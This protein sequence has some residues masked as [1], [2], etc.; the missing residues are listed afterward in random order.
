MHIF[1]ISDPPHLLKTACNNVR[2][3]KTDGSK[4]LRFGE[5]HILWKHFCQVPHLYQTNKLQSRKLHCNHFCNQSYGK[6]KVRYAAQLLSDT[7]ANLM[8]AR[9]E[10][11]K[12]VHGSRV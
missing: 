5:H 7:V 2:S 4:C 12:K 9:G 10:E 1:L 11:M 8:K 3:S 6:M